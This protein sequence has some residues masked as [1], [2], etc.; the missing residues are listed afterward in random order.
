[1]QAL[2][3]WRRIESELDPDWDEARLSFTVDDEVAIGDAAAVLAPLGPGRHRGELRFQVSRRGAGPERLVNLLRRLDRKRIWGTLTLVDAQTAP[4]PEPQPE[5]AAALAEAT[6][7]A[8]S[9]A[10]AWDG[11]VARL[12]PDWRDVL[13]ELEL[14][15][16]DYLAQAALLGAP[17]NPTRVPGEVKLQ[18]RANSHGSGG[19]GAPPGLVRRCFERMDAAEVRG[20]LRVVNALSG[21]DNVATQGVVWRVAGRAV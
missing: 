18:F 12:P 1:M 15:S 5:Q 6:A 2:E 4:R 11:E 20:R 13:G 10:E 7:L 9:L 3:Q 8:S 16:T 17:L 19:Y 14:E 21:T